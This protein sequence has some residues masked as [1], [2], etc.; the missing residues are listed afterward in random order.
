LA[1]RNPSIQQPRRANHRASL[2][3]LLGIVAVA[4]IPVGIELTRRFPGVALIEA[5]WGIPVA[6]V[7]GIGALLFA[8]GA[9]G[10]IARTLERSGGAARIRL[11]RVLAIAGICIGLAATISVVVYEVLLRLER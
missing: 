11:G 5:A 3:V 2:A 10:S 6:V 1:A 4:V 8:R 9:R 7:T